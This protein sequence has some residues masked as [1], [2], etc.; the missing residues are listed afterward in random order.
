MYELA[1]HVEQYDYLLQEEKISKSLSRGTIYKNPTISYALTECEDSQ[2]VS[3][4]AAEIVID[5][6][7]VFKGLTQ[8]KSNDA[9]TRLATEE[10]V[11]TKVYI[12]DIT[13][14]DAIFN[15]LLLAKI[16][17]LRPGHNIPKAEELKGNIYCKYHNLNKLTTNSC[18]VFCDDIQSWIDKGKLKF[19]KKQMTV[20]IDPFPSVTVG[21]VDA[22]LPKNKRKWKAEFVPIQ[23]IPK[24]NS[25]PQ[26]KIDLFS[27]EPPTELLGP[28]I[29]RPVD[30][31]C[32]AAIA[33]HASY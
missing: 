24:Q 15:Q 4:D 16:I 23:H 14:A 7:Y 27:N 6:P 32:Y 25:W 3:V 26:I 10:M 18:V 1:Q 19:P 31:W 29:V 33:R 22:H 17:K 8:I 20:N 21:M 28:A 12:F 30:Q 9:K 11:K 5:K 13:K 2:Y